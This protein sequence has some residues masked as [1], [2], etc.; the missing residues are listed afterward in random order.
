MPMNL[1]KITEAERQLRVLEEVKWPG[2][3]VL[4]GDG[5]VHMAI[6]KGMI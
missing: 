3:L 2:V 6:R 4:T 1:K 5:A